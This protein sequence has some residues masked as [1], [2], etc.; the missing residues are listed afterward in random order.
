MTNTVHSR[1]TPCAAC[2][3]F[4]RS[5]PP[6]CESAKFF[7][8]VI[9]RQDYFTIY[10]VFGVKNVV[11]ILQHIPDYKYLETLMLFLFEA[12]SRVDNPISSCTILIISLQQKLETLQSWVT[13]LKARL[14]GGY[15]SANPSLFLAPLGSSSRFLSSADNIAP[16]VIPTTVNLPHP[17]ILS[18]NG[19]LLGY[20]CSEGLFRLPMSTENIASN[21]LPTTI[22]LSE[23]RAF[24]TYSNMSDYQALL[25]GFAGGSFQVGSVAEVAGSSNPNLTDGR[26]AIAC[27]IQD[28]TG[29][30]IDGFSQRIVQ[31]SSILLAQAIALRKACTL[32]V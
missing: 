12:Q 18:I 17:G 27:I 28:A 11:S 10:S 8:R 16:E 22:N 23:H 7:P 3:Y 30:I 4:C 25:E 29:H 14:G 13:A 15:S 6:F 21:I 19:D 20:P 26:A 9:N 2:S 31:V 5:C 1:G 24:S 32:C